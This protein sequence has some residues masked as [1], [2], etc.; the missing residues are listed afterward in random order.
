MKTKLVF[1]LGLCFSV[2]LNLSAQIATNWLPGRVLVKLV[3]DYL[4]PCVYALNQSS[5]TDHGTLLALNSTNGAMLGEITVG[6]NPTDM[7]ATPAGVGEAAPAASDDAATVVA[8]VAVEA[9]VAEAEPDTPAT[10]ED[11]ASEPVE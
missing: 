4:R 10:S 7:A 3:P 2:A 8:D 6:I 5:G 11:A 1:S 9:L